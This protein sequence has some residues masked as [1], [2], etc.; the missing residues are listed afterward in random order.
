MRTTWRRFL[1]GT[2]VVVAAAQA[3]TSPRTSTAQTATLKLMD[4]NIQHGVDTSN[5]NNLDRV[6]TWIAQVSPDVVSL[7]E[8]EKQNGYNGN[9]DEPAVLESLVE[10]KTGVAWYRCFAQRTGGATGQGNLLLSRIPIESCDAHL[11]SASRS[12]AMARIRF[13]GA[14]VNVFSTHLDDASASTRTTQISEL[15]TYASSKS[16]QRLIMGDFN[17]W[18]GSTEIQAMTASYEDAWA[19]AKLDGTAVAY[20]G[21]EAGNT[22]NS[23]I[24][25]IWRSKGATLLKLLGA[26]V[27]DTGTISDHRPVSATY[28]PVT[29]TPSSLLPPSNLRVLH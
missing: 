11:L 17:A 3:L 23:R 9:A 7:N 13:N 1:R 29:S 19:K 18:P 27:Y 26:Q 5:V 10:S 22:R 25:Y 16:E 20:A 28:G 12:V 4:W 24:D 14:V 6:A 2:I 8:V 21:N 15:K